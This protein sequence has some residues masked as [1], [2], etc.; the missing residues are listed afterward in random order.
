MVSM[1]RAMVSAARA[2]PRGLDR[3][4]PWRLITEASIRDVVIFDISAGWNFTGPS[5]N[6]ECDPLTSSLTKITRTSRNS[7]RT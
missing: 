5:S 3:R 4:K 7:T 6:H 1:G 2:K